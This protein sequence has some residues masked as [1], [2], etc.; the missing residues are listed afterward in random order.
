MEVI[1]QPSAWGACSGYFCGNYVVYLLLTWMPFYLVHERHFSLAATAAIS[2]AA[3][4]G[5]AAGALA[6]GWLSDVWIAAGASPTLARKTLC[7][8]GLMSSGL[9]LLV[10]SVSLDR[11]CVVLLVAG[12]AC[13]GLFTPQGHAINQT[14]A[15]PE[16]AGTWTSFVLSI[17]NVS[18]IIGPTVTGFVVER[19]GH[20][21]WAFALTAAI[22]CTGALS[23]GFFVGPVK[24]IAWAPAIP[25]PATA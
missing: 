25:A 14:L 6:S 4:L 16:L 15:G 21:F 11:P 2:G 3:F 20:F 17:G 22:A 5:K 23:Y 8:F 19:T 18:G 10:S 1:K 13:L 24:P 12:S 7:C 9:L